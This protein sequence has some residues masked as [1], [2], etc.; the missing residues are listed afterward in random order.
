MKV[1]SGVSQIMSRPPLL[2]FRGDNIN[3]E[4]FLLKLNLLKPTIPDSP[5]RLVK[6]NTGILSNIYPTKTLQSE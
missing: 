2:D 3:N 6:E 5:P 1:W 4:L